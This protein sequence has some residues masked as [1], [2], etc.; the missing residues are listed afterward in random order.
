MEASPISS[1]PWRGGADRVTIKSVFL[2]SPIVLVL[3]ELFI[4]TKG[5]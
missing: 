1:E 3:A 4:G 2:I 5:Q